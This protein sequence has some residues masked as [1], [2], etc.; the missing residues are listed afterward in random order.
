MQRNNSN[1]EPAWVNCTYTTVFC[2]VLFTIQNTVHI[3]QFY[4]CTVFC[5]LYCI[6]CIVYPR[7]HSP[8][9]S[10]PMSH[11]FL[12][13]LLVIGTG[14]GIL[15]YTARV[16]VHRLFPFHLQYL[17]VFHSLFI[18]HWLSFV[19]LL[20]DRRICSHSIDPSLADGEFQGLGLSLVPDVVVPEAEYGV[21]IKQKSHFKFLP[22]P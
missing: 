6:F 17:G 10:N 3:H 2:I 12:T 16:S 18:C 20:Y 19:F 15:G 9:V 1:A 21:R 13:R 5:V 11:H 7:A 22:W 14:S 4:I 8:L